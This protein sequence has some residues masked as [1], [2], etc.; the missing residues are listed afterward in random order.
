MHAYLN[1]L[2]S[3]ANVSAGVSV[4]DAP[5]VPLT[6]TPMDVSLPSVDA[7]SV[8]APTVDANLPGAL[9]VALDADKPKKK[10][11]FGSFLGRKKD[12]KESG[13]PVPVTPYF[14]LVTS[15]PLCSSPVPWHMLVNQVTTTQRLCSKTLFR[16][17]DS[18]GFSGALPTAALAGA[19]AAA[20]GATGLAATA[21]APDAS[22]PEFSAPA[23]DAPDIPKVDAPAAALGFTPGTTPTAPVDTSLTLRLD[24]ASESPVSL[25][26]ADTISVPLANNT[27]DLGSDRADAPPPSNWRR[28]DIVS[29]PIAPI[30]EAPHGADSQADSVYL[31]GSVLSGPA[32]RPL[33]E[34]AD[35]GVLGTSGSTDSAPLG[36]SPTQDSPST[37]LDIERTSH[38]I[39]T[40]HK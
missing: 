6:A 8:D 21:D 40:H 32:C 24:N 23:V 3:V 4:P 16:V 22:A 30:A 29:I 10:T 12:K 31:T 5:E 26:N 9:D 39:A 11:F 36:S 33:H 14:V 25:N 37:Q 15:P 2:K 18:S 20:L 7:P 28:E 17:G 13:V 34:R 1:W 27:A 38:D 19:G 35:A